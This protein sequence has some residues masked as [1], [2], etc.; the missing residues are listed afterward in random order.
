MLKYSMNED[1]MRGRH[2]KAAVNI[3]SVCMVLMAE[4]GLFDQTR[5]DGAVNDSQ[6]LA[7]DHRASCEEMAQ[8]QWQAGHPLAYRLKHSPPRRTGR[9]IHG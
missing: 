1:S 5:G 3:A 2:M 8:L 9:W 6:H 7:R 4:P